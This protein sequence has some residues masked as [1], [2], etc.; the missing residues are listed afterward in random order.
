MLHN[1]ISVDTKVYA[2]QLKQKST[3]GVL[4]GILQNFRIA[5]FD[6]NFGGLLLKRKLRRRRASSDPCGFT[7]P[8][9][10]FFQCSYLLSHTTT[11][12]PQIIIIIII[13]IIIIN[14]LFILGKNTINLQ[15]YR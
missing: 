6:N 5:S 8:L 10:T 7:F 14:S 15:L 13:V 4:H 9:S 12:S 3:A 1:S 2:L 11:L